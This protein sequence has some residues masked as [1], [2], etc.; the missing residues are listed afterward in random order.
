MPLLRP[1]LPS[2]PLGAQPERGFLTTRKDL[3]KPIDKLIERQPADSDDNEFLNIGICLDQ[4]AFHFR[5][6]IVGADVLTEA[7][8][9][10]DGNH[11]IHFCIRLFRQL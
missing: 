9:M 10:R 8:N 2:A 7:R 6:R 11:L 4:F 1:K 5:P 3:A